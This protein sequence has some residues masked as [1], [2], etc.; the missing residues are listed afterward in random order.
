MARLFESALNGKSNARSRPYNAYIIETMYGCINTMSDIALL[1]NILEN[2]K[3]QELNPEKQRL[4]NIIT[5]QMTLLGSSLIALSNDEIEK[6]LST[7]ADVNSNAETP[8]FS[9]ANAAYN[10]DDDSSTDI[11]TDIV[12]INQHEF[13]GK[14]INSIEAAHSTKNKMESALP[15]IKYDISK[16]FKYHTASIIK[17]AQA[18]AKQLDEMPNKFEFV[19]DDAAKLLFALSGSYSASNIPLNQAEMLL[20]LSGSY[21]SPSIPVEQAEILLSFYDNKNSSTEIE[22]DIDEDKNEFESGI[23]NLVNSDF[24]ASTTDA[25]KDDENS[26]ANKK[27]ADEIKSD[28]IA[29]EP[30]DEINSNETISTFSEIKAAVYDNDDSS[31]EIETDID[32]IKMSLKAV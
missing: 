26:E 9:E 28:E 8:S 25:I 29:Q 5:Q 6:V 18:D 3:P 13:T 14:P 24:S 2:L 30:A 31:T 12:E 10:N 11:E 7:S 32:E 23:V 21:P 19:G 4:R 17:K 27:S 20:A 1:K 15:I 16:K 22:T